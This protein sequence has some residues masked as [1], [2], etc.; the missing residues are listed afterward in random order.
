MADTDTNRN[1][2]YKYGQVFIEFISDLQN[3]DNISVIIIF[4]GS[5]RPFIRSFELDISELSREKYK[6]P[7]EH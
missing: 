4:T 6:N 3:H 7:K 5:F 2:L 1:I